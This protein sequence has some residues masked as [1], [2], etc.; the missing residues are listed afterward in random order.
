MKFTANVNSRNFFDE[1]RRR[2]V[3]R[4]GATYAVIGWLLIQIAATIVPALALPSAITSAVVLATLLGFPLALVL[5][6]A[7]EFTAEGVRRE[8]D[9]PSASTRPRRRT[10]R[11][12]VALVSVVAIATAGLYLFRAQQRR[13]ASAAAS[14]GGSNARSDVPGSLREKSIAVLPFRNISDDKENAFFA[15]G[16]QEEILTTLAKLSD[17][18]VISRTSVMQFR[19]A[20]E[21]RLPDIAASLGVAH[22]LQGSVQRAGNRVRVTAHLID[23]RTDTHLWA[24]HFDRELSDVFA[25]QTEIAQT[26][27][28]QLQAVLSP[29]E[30]EALRAH[31]TADVTAYDFYLR[32]RE[33]DRAGRATVETLPQQI[34]ALDEAVS[35]DPKFV[36]A[37]C[38]LARAHGR[39]FFNNFDATPA[40]LQLAWKALEAAARV[41]P[42]AGE[43]H[44][45]RGLLHYWGARDYDGALREL[46]LARRTMPNETDVVY[47]SGLIQ[48]RQGRWE[49]S[50]KNLE[51]AARLDPRNATLLSE[52]ANTNY[53]SLRRYDDAA[54]VCDEV[55]VWKPDFAAELA[56]ARVDRLGSGDLR[57]MESV[58]SGPAAK[59]VS[60][61]QLAV[62]RLDLSLLQRDFAAAG[63]ALAASKA[64]DFPGG[65]YV[66]PR[67]W[68]AALIAQ[69]TGDHEQANAQFLA[70]RE[71]AAANVAR[72]ADDAKALM[73]LADIDARLGNKDDAVRQAE[74]AVELLPMSEDALDGLR[75]LSRLA[76]VY[77]NVGDSARALDLLEQV[78]AQPSGPHYGEL[79]LDERWDPVRGDARFQKILASVAPKPAA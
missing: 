63:Q 13:A 53:V 4:V 70:A 55:L 38:L 58:I 50:T 30:E 8:Q 73:T 47:Y 77:A 40:R 79:M 51:A 29:D 46:A 39:M 15:D 45:A 2:N 27:A 43:V 48:R 65:G 7:F 66:T 26:I 44:L 12:F 59:G 10:A 61:E 37:L 78:V 52:L 60:A 25:I 76:G 11:K 9:I 22:V 56:R 23:A 41:Q 1:L 5:A 57:R 32:A 14:A 68:Y 72:R 21:R 35:R 36:P 24:D 75:I 67:E 42:H 20:A 16:V 17:L 19:D 34:S 71:R 64:Q 3:Y 49:E 18:K 62:T 54:R 74:R 28:G 6:W 69:G 33:I 31:P